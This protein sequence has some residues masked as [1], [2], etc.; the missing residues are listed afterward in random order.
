MTISAPLISRAKKHKVVI[1]WVTRTKAEWRGVVA[2][3]ETAEGDVGLQTASLTAGIV[4]RWN[5]ER[6]PASGDW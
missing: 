6:R 4:S 2:G 3:A 1:Q 5:A